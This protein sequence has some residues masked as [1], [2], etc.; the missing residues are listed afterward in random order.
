M[1]ADVGL[2]IAIIAAFFLSRKRYGDIFTPLFIYVAIWCGC[3]FLFR[4]RLVNY[5]V[6]GTSVILVIAGSIL[7]F[8]LGCLIAGRPRNCRGS[9]FSVSLQRLEKVIRVLDYTSL[10][11]LLIFLLRS[12]R[13]FGLS[14]YLNDPDVIRLGYEDLGRVGPLALLLSAIY[15]LSVCSLIHVLVSKKVRWFAG[16]GLILPAVQGFLTMSRNN[17]GVPLI[18]G[19]FVWFYYR[20][21]RGLN[22][23]IMTV[24]AGALA[25]VLLYFVGVGF[26]YGKEATAPEYSLYRDRDISITSSVGLQL[27]F[28]YMYATG[29]FP[30]LQAA[31]GDVHGRL[32]G[33]RTLFPIARLLYGIGL[34][35]E[36][37]ENAT[38]EFYYV[39]V[40]FNTETYLFGIY[41]DFGSAGIIVYPFLLGC[42]GTRLYL[43][44]RERPTIF[45]VGCTAVLMVVIV[46]SVFISLASTFQVWL[47]VITLLAI[48]RKCTV[49]LPNVGLTTQGT[50]PSLHCAR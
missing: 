49:L 33:E 36:R 42:V 9:V 4:M 22:R 21:W 40:P 8:V 38:L 27:A 6:L 46:Y 48:S 14:A 2:V 29:N 13:V 24:C 39:P 20:G 30:T 47:W 18:A 35:Q 7:A 44:M 19:A 25:L 43:A 23:R 32:W 1:L 10:A 50:L 26:W 16:V 11:G 5:D 3:L 15:P 12:A 17:L 31:M 34:L 37:P 28:P 41:E 45:S